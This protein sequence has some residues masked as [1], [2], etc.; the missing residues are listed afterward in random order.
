ML[1]L[2][3]THTVTDERVTD[4]I[5]SALEGGSNYWYMIDIS[6][7]TLVNDAHYLVEQPMRGGNLCVGLKNEEDGPVNGLTQWNL[8]RESCKQGLEIMSRTYPRHFADWLNKN[9]D[10]ITGDVFL[11]CAL[12]GE[13]I[14]G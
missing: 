3:I 6:Q 14:F 10:A 1:K 12:F 4:L 8:N 13:I 11:Q 9:D 5:T 2:K 7:S